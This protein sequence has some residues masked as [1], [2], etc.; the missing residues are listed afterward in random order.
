MKF[1]IYKKKFKENKREVNKMIGDEPDYYNGINREEDA[2]VKLGDEVQDWWDS[3]TDKL[4]PYYPDKLH[5][6]GMNEAWEGLSW[7]DQLEIY[8]EENGYGDGVTV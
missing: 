3:L 2:R 6:M 7:E 8:K 4:E 1:G 5:L